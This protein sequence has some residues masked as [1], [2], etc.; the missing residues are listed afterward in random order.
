[1]VVMNAIKKLT[2]EESITPS[3]SFKKEQD[4]KRTSKVTF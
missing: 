2:K 1:M 3:E 4:A